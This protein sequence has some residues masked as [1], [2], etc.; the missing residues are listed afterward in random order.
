MLFLK[1][2]DLKADTVTQV[3]GLAEF[4]GFPFNREEESRGVIEEIGKLC[5]FGNLKGLEVNQPGN[6]FIPYFE[7]NA[8]FRKGQVGD[9]ANHLSPSMAEHVHKV[10]EEKL[11]GSGLTFELKI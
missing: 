3:K 4:L 2:E 5:S 7:N 9:W 6:F 8:Y 11:H 1:Y 10:I